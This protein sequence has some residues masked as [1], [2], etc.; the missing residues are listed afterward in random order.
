M[1]NAFMP[2]GESHT[3]LSPEDHDGLATVEF[4]VE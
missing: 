1:T 2:I 3:E 4:G